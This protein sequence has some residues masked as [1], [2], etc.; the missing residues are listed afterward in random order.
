MTLPTDIILPEPEDFNED[1]QEYISN[2]T[3]KLE[4]MYSNISNNVNGNFRN[5]ADTDGSQWIPT[6]GGTTSTGTYTYTTQI[7]WV[8]RQ[9]IMVD[10]WANISW[11]ATTAT[12]FIVVDLPYGVI[13]SDAQLTFIG[14]CNTSLIAFASGTSASIVAIAG[15]YTAQVYTY[16]SAISIA[17]LPVPASGTINY[18]LRYI[19][20]SDD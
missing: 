6:L 11:T 19:G 20:V 15:T 14:E 12:G 16:G 4:M 5:Y 17:T 1:A 3:E 18:H 8:Y 7:A 10:V 2:L 13:L 9:G